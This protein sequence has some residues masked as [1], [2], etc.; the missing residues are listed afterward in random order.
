MSRLHATGPR[1]AARC[2]TVVAA[3]CGAFAS[4]PDAAHAQTA[5]PAAPAASAPAAAAS[6]PA[7]TTLPAVRVR[8]SADSDK[9]EGSGSYAPASTGTATG[10]KLA[11][12]DT[13][14]SVSV[15]TR[16]QIDDQ[17]MRNV[18]DALISTT[19]VSV[20]AVDRGR[21]TLVV[22]GF[23]VNN[24][25]F[26]GIPFATGNIG[27]EELSTAIYD[28]IEVVRGAT[29]LLSGF[30]DPSAAVN[31]VRKRADSK[32]FTGS[33]SVELGSW[34]HR[35][36]TVD[37]STPLN[38]DG[39]L[40][41]R[42]VG[43]AYSQDA[44]IDLEH[45]RGSVLFATMEADLTPDTRL[46]LGASDQRDKRRGVLW[47]P[48]PL[49]YSDG[50]RTDWPRNFT[51]ATRWNR[52][53]TSEQTAFAR[54]EHTLPN[55]WTLRADASWR[56]QDEESKMLWFANED[57]LD[58][59]TG[60]G[61]TADGP[62]HY[63]AQPRQLHL[64]FSASGPFE[65]FGRRHEAAFGVLRSRL[66]DG[67]NNRDLIGTLPPVGNF[68]AWDG[69]Y[70]EP[71]MGPEYVASKGTTTQ[72]A[73]Y[74]VARFQVTDPLKLI[75]GARVASWKRNE[76]AAAWTANPYTTEHKRV[77]TPY[78]GIVYDLTRSLSAYASY[79]TIYKPHTTERTADGSFLEP[80]D[81]KS[82]E[83]GLKGE[84]LDGRLQATTALFRTDQDNFPV[85]VGSVGNMPIYAGAQ[86]TKS[87]GWE[88]EVVGQITQQWNVLA[89]WTQYSA[90]DA[91]GV[92]VNAHHPR[93]QF[94]L[95]TQ[96]ALPAIASG[97][98][99][100][101]ALRWEDQPP[102]RQTN[103]VGVEEETGQPAYTLV[104]L[105]ARYAIDRHWSL[106]LNVNNVFDKTY[107][108]ASAWWAG[109][110]Y[111]EPRNVKLTAKY[112]F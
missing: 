89:G 44:F 61:I 76:E 32:T 28:R 93:K 105:S 25:Q 10:L 83:V 100:G 23:E 70:P 99:V 2:L 106:Q 4:A 81:G 57:Q 107:R 77:V 110:L 3:A 20:K 80:L 92:H 45:S 63:H 37:L 67:W 30:G 42:V 66:A 26:D 102:K 64:A 8:A 73:I 15:V 65:W 22:R 41:A 87:Q 109:S 94:K 11:P 90:K 72:H 27:L 48:L 24:F 36:G 101:G 59:D 54:L 43:H 68:N 95:T 14:Q 85:Q 7:D 82:Y 46:T 5:A 31:L 104:D 33:A 19:G 49:W 58:R 96:A 6:A 111:G 91:Q 79:T 34:K 86:G 112:Q 1:P 17:G 88:F 97:L 40:R 18:A 13:P 53:D 52:W 69:S 9:T 55:R 108:T 62:Y 39:S 50:T 21:N 74:G 47:F 38:T 12:R 35:A 78:A 103:P 75:A 98:S 29:G 71:E 16:Q 84:F 60:V 51:S 56:R